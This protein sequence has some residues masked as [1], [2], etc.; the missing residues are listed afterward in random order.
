MT[1]WYT[2][3]HSF[4]CSFPLWFTCDFESRKTKPILFPLSSFWTSPLGC[5]DTLEKGMATHSS[6]LAWRIPWTEEPG[7]LQSMVSQRVGHNWATN[8]HF[9]NQ[10]QNT[11]TPVHVFLSLLRTPL[12]IILVYS[13]GPES[14]AFLLRLTHAHLPV[15]SGNTSI[16]HKMSRDR[17]DQWPIYLKFCIQINHFKPFLKAHLDWFGTSNNCYLISWKM[18]LLLSFGVPFF[19][20]VGL[21]TFLLL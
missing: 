1:Q 16:K 9:I 19:Y 5:E 7:G 18:G 14:T 8:T 4:L 11:H 3:R 17:I 12:S 6:I 10:F 20:Y 2:Y 13:Q 15:W 21:R